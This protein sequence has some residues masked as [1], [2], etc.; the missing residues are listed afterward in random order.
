MG[1]AFWGMSKGKAAAER[2]IL[3]VGAT[4]VT[5]VWRWDQLKGGCGL[6]DVKPPRL[7]ILLPYICICIGKLSHG[8]D[9]IP[10][11]GGREPSV[12]L[13]LSFGV[14]QKFLPVSYWGMG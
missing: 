5:W 4:P 14:V 1:C 10:S 13:V 7:S 8:S 2:G 9:G 11:G 6:T 3:N 12:R